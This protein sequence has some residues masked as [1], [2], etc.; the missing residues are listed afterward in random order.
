M[1]S[2]EIPTSPDPTGRRN[3]SGRR[4]SG[5]R[6]EDVE[7]LFDE[8]DDDEERN[9]AVER[10]KQEALKKK[11]RSPFRETP[12]HQRRLQ[13]YKDCIQMTTE[14]VRRRRRRRPSCL[15]AP[16]PRTIDP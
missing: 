3:S 1:N 2:I 4:L 13:M 16:T 11:T 15:T 8:N 12:G 6:P 10:K 14:N 5:W 9:K 7:N